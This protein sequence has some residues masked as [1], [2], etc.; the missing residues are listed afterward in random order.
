MDIVYHV[1]E[2]L[3]FLLTGGMIVWIITHNQPAQPEMAKAP[4]YVREREDLRPR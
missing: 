2:V 1:S 4:V 3:F